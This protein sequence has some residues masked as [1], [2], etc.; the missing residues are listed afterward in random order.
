MTSLDVFRRFA[1]QRV[2][3][4]VNVFIYALAGFEKY[5]ALATALLT[6]IDN[7]VF[8]GVTSELTLA[9]AHVVPMKLQRPDLISKYETLL[10][11]R[12]SFQVVTVSRSVLRDAANQRAVLGRKLADAIHLATARAT[13]C[14]FFLTADK[15]LKV[16]PDVQH[17]SL[18]DLLV[19]MKD[20]RT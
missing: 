15:S 17:I 4:D 9:E 11:A 18:D 1:N 6:N 10:Q 8:A 5:H 20:Q 19:T 12:G 2:Y 13:G 16:T 14:S 7:G 3:I